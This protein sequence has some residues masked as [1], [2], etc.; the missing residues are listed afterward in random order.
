[1]LST[2]TGVLEK[3][4]SSVVKVIGEFAACLF[5]DVMNFAL[6]YSIYNLIHFSG[7]HVRNSAETTRRICCSFIYTIIIVT[8]TFSM[9]EES[10]SDQQATEL[11]HF[12]LH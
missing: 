4:V 12:M 10:S 7:A 8:G 6:R 9:G 1:M 5:V 3:A 11:F 2:P